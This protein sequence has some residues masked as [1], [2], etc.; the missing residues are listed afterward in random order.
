MTPSPEDGDQV[1]DED[2]SE[3]YSGRPVRRGFR[4]CSYQLIVMVMEMLSDSR[5]CFG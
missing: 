3:E 1:S 4:P 5:L 2:W